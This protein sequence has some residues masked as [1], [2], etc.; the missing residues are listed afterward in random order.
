MLRV[1]SQNGEFDFP[2]D[3]ICIRITDRTVYARTMNDSRDIL[4]AVYSNPEKVKKAMDTLLTYHS[5]KMPFYQFP[6]EK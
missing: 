5:N 4:I 2:Y 3:K 1:I 6:E